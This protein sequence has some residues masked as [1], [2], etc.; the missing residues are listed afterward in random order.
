MKTIKVAAPHRLD[1]GG[2]WDLPP[3]FYYGQQ[4]SPKTIT[5]ALDVYTTVTFS[6]K[7]FFTRTNTI[8]VSGD[9]T[10]EW[11][12]RPEQYDYTS[13]FGLI[14]A[15]LAFFEMQNVT[16]EVSAGVPP[17]IGLGGSGVLSV[18]LVSACLQM[19]G[20]QHTRSI[21]ARIAHE[22]EDGFFSMTGYQDQLAALTG[23]VQL[24]HWDYPPEESDNQP[25]LPPGDWQE[26]E[27]RL[28][29][30]IV[31]K[32][33]STEINQKQVHSFMLPATRHLWVEIND[34]TQQA[35][36]A[37]SNHEWKGLTD[38][39][40]IEHDI[41]HI[42][43]PERIR[44]MEQYKE[45]TDGMSGAF[46]TAGAGQAVCWYFSDNI[47]DIAIVK[48]VWGKLGCLILPFKVAPLMRNSRLE[49]H[50]L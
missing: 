42:I 25:L 23:G 22:V 1:I 6:A 10:T 32:H 4:Y 39:I 12:G 16:V 24:W 2:T 15:I 17:R 44:G 47:Q 11:V 34:A 26:L 38:A 8:L 40:R 48:A 46:A 13:Q 19:L 41:R 33:D 35:A 50:D 9:S 20:R 14:Q 5:I 29:I 7:P 45:A 3:L 43:A 31:G 18:A 49:T 30:A 27:Q 37:I 28:V 21:V 36:D